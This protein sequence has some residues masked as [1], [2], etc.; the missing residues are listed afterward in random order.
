MRVLIDYRPALRHRTGVGEW[1][2]SLVSALAGK[3]HDGSIQ[4]S[5]LDLTIFSSSWK[6]R[7]KTTPDGCESIDCRVPVRVLNFSWNRFSWPPIELMTGQ[8]FDVVHSPHP[9]L[10]PT[11]QAARIITIHDLDF[12]EH[13]ERSDAE[14]RNDYPRLVK[15][16]SR[17]ANH[18]I[19]PSQFT[20]SEVTRKLGISQSQITVCYN[21]APDWTPR[22]SQPNNGH[23]LFVGALGKRK[24]LR[25]LLDAYRLLID[26]REINP[27]PLILTG[28]DTPQA[29]DY[30]PSIESE[31]FKGRVQRTGYVDRSTLRTL[32]EKASLLVLPSLHEG[33]GLPVVEAMTVGVPVVV[34][35]R[36]ALQEVSGSAGLIVNPLDPRDIAN[37]IKRLLVDDH[38]SQTCVERGFRQAARFSWNRSAE[39][40]KMAYKHAY[41]LTSS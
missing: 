32:Y 36:G 16:H 19:V 26:D 5:E 14:I 12:L 23:I 40:L 29:T 39:S 28:P 2:H 22:K 34:S 13:P 30:L 17:D 27:P 31:P 33:F 38:L 37:A 8:A 3:I 7:L 10:I 41:N 35:D 1:I 18:I 4:K 9:L 25:R 15:T 21:G 11:D 24:N 20:G 6:H